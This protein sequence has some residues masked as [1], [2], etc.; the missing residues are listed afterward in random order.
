MAAPVRRSVVLP[1]DDD[2]R[3]ARGPNGRWYFFHKVG[4]R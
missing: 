4:C 2:W 1:L 3:A